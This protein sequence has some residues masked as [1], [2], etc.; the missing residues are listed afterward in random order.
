M[1]RQTRKTAIRPEVKRAVYERD[2]GRCILCGK[3]GLP[4]AHFIGRAHGGLGIEENI[5][6]LCREC[7]D[8]YDNSADRKVIR[9]ILREYLKSKYPEWDE[10]KLNYHK[11][12]GGL[13]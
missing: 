9:E 11:Y 4:N 12:V 8:R 2:G 1:H 13:L 6:T 5:I 10:S 3:R 7:H